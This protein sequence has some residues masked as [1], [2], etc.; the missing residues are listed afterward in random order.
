MDLGTWIGEEEENRGWELLG[1]A[2]DVMARAGVAPE[3][4]PVAFQALYMAEGS[5]WFWWFGEDQ[6]SNNDAEFDDLFRIHLKNIYRS[7]GA[8]PPAELE[9]HIVPH[10]VLISLNKCPT[11][12]GETG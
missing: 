3:T 12:S 6:D 1:Q 9:Q 11:F 4:A 10:K 7:L 2:R 8:T 5:D